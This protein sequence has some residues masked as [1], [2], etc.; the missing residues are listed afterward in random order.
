M[1][2]SLAESLSLAERAALWRCRTAATLLDDAVRVPG[3]PFRVGVDPLVGLLPVAGDIATALPSLYVLAEAYRLGAPR[4]TLVR[5][6][7]NVGLD[8]TVG[9]MPV[10][11]TLFDAV[12]KPNRRNVE[13]L[14]ST[15]F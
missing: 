14:E 1:T 11:G 7:A 2:D 13:L 8:L 12:W 4:S 10:L 9:S 5:M 6:M 15:L 3:T